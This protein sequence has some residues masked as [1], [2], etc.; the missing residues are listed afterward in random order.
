MPEELVQYVID[1][2]GAYPGPL[3]K[4][5]LFAQLAP[6][7]TEADIDGLLLGTAPVEGS[8]A[9]VVEIHL[10]RGHFLQAE[11]LLGQLDL[12]DARSCWLAAR[13]ELAAGSPQAALDLVDGAL[14]RG[15]DAELCERMF[16]TRGRALLG[17]GKYAEALEQVER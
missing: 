4:F 10:D 16:A 3:R 13:Y 14:S 8:V 5:A 9:H 12:E 17:V 7:S 11:P 2:V 15:G 6:V 1:Q